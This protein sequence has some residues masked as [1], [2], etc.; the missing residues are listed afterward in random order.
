MVP[1]APRE[2]AFLRGA[3][4]IAGLI[5]KI[6]LPNRLNKAEI[7]VV[8]AVYHVEFTVFAFSKTNNVCPSI[9]ICKIA[10]SSHG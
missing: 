4:L 2:E 9:F 1:K 7:A 5:T 3:Y 10:S 6:L 8:A